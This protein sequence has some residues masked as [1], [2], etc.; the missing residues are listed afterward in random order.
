MK[1]VLHFKKSRTKMSEFTR[2]NPTTYLG[3]FLWLEHTTDQVADDTSDVW[4][5]N[6]QEAQCKGQKELSDN[7]L[8]KLPPYSYYSATAKNVK[9]ILY[10]LFSTN[11]WWFDLSI[12]VQILTDP[13][14]NDDW[15]LLM[16]SNK[17]YRLLLLHFSFIFRLY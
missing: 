3:H 13:F 10:K 2:A 4:W 9:Q 5:R 14:F 15:Q 8:T 6:T 12:K 7:L 17:T 16:C 11:K 1:Y